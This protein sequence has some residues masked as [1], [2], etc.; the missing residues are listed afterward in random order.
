[1]YNNHGD[2]MK[3]SF[4]KRLGAYLIDIMF[5]SIIVSLI[6]SGIS[7]S[8]YKKAYTEYEDIMNKYAEQE[9][10]TDE[11]LNQMKPVIYDIQKSSTLVSSMSLIFTIIY[12]VVFQYLNKGQT[13]GKKILGLKVVENGKEPS[14]KAIILRTIFIS[15]IFSSFFAIVLVYV[16]NSNNYY[17]VY[18]IISY[19]EMAFIFISA[20]FILYR[21]DKLGLHDMIAHTEVI[22]ERG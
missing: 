6:S 18:S 7:N 17:T 13:L 5:V 8:E 22:D 19:M 16:L 14:L 3:A 2:F 11:Y 20:L 10:T 21:K 12:F 15:S 9:I 1:M 4:F